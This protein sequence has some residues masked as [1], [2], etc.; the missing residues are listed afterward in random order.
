MDHIEWGT[1]R[2]CAPT[3]HEHGAQ[4]GEH[5]VDHEYALSLDTGSAAVVIEGTA[6]ELSALL[7]GLRNGLHQLD[8]LHDTTAHHATA[9]YN[10]PPF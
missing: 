10:E 5:A 7:D 1:A 9:T 4:I 6:T 3:I 8:E 2:Y